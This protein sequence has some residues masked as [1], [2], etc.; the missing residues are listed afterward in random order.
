MLSQCG[1]LSEDPS[2]LDL[3]FMCRQIMFWNTQGVAS[4]LFRCTFSMIVKNYK[5]SMVVLL[6]PRI[7]GLNAY[8]FIKKNGFNNSHCV[9]AEGFSGGIWIL[10]RDIFD[11]EIVR[12]HTQFIH[13]WVS[14]NNQLVS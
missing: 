12:N 10:W 5:P 2:F 11:V 6:E 7:N 8:D 3:S 13:L 4:P 1:C 9:E 14:H